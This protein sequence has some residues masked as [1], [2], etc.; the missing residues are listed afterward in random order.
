MSPESIF[1][2]QLCKFSI[3][4]SRNFASLHPF[5]AILHL[6]SLASSHMR[7]ETNVP[8]L[9]CRTKYV[10]GDMTFGLGQLLSIIE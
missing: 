5:F 4:I 7:V 2:A 9:C 1:S 8:F 3:R 10:F 6:V